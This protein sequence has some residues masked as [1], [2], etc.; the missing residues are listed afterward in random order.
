MKFFSVRQ[1]SLFLVGSSSEKKCVILK[2]EEDK[3]TFGTHN[4]QSPRPAVLEPGFYLRVA[5][6]RR[7]ADHVMAQPIAD[8]S[9]FEW[10]GEL[11][12][13]TPNPEPAF[14]LLAIAA[15]EAA[16]SKEVGYANFRVVQES[17]VDVDEGILSDTV[18]DSPVAIKT[19]DETSE[20]SKVDSVASK[21]VSPPNVSEL[22]SVT[23]D[24]FL[25]LVSQVTDIASDLKKANAK[26][27]KT[28]TQASYAKL[29]AESVNVAWK[30]VSYRSIGHSCKPSSFGWL[31]LLG[32]NAFN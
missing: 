27:L 12:M 15:L 9:L 25:T 13:S 18:V 29:L 28:K 6:P 22:E 24:R 17:V 26:F 23:E 3:C 1:L 8:P 5:S 11:I 16:P 4:T 20:P 2:D 7:E 31:Y 14:W 32:D 21:V 10:F 30:K 19:E